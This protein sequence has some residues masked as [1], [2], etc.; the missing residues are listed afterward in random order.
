MSTEQ[1]YTKYN[2]DNETSDNET[3]DD[4]TSVLSDTSS[5]FEN[6]VANFALLAKNLYKPDVN[7][8]Q[9]NNL[10]SEVNFTKGRIYSLYNSLDDNIESGIKDKNGAKLYANSNLK[11]D[12]SA[13]TFNTTKNEVTSIINIDSSDRD[14]QVY[15]Q[16]TNLQLRLPRVYKNILNFQIVQI[17]L[18]SAF[19]YFRKAKNNITISINEQSRYLDSENNVINNV[20]AIVDPN[21]F[22]KLNSITNTIREGSYDINSLINEL[23]IH[24][25]TPPLF[26]DFIGGFNQFVPLFAANGDLFASFN[27]PGDYYFDSVL[28]EYITAPTAE[29]IVTKYFETRYAGQTS[30]TIDNIKIA[31]YYPV[32]KE[33][34]LDNNYNGKAIDF[35]LANLSLLLPT[36]T[37]RTRCLYY[38]QGLNDTYVLSVIQ[39]NITILDS[40]RLAHTFR[41]TLINKYNVFYN[42]FNN[43]ISINSPSLN[44]SLVNLI[45]T[46]KTTYYN[47]EFVKYGIT[48]NNYTDLYVQ[49][50]LYLAILTDMYNFLQY[51]FST[52]FGITYNTFTLDYYG[53]MSNYV[54]L[55]SGCNANIS[56]NYDINVITN[57]IT[58]I[59]NNILTYYQTP[60]KYYW[61]SLSSN[62][63][64]NFSNAT[65]I[66]YYSGNPYNLQSDI[67]EE[68]HTLINNDT[69]YSSKLLNHVDAVV[70]INNTSYTIF[71]FKSSY[72]QTLQVEVL[73]RPTKYRYPEYNVNYDLSHSILFDNSYNFILNSSNNIFIDPSI[74]VSPLPGFTSI[75]DSNFGITFS[76]SYA[77]WLGSNASI[78]PNQLYDYYSFVTPLPDLLNAIAYKYTT[79][80]NVSAYPYGTNFSSQLKVFLYRDIGAFYA[81]ILSYGFES[82]YNYIL[83]NSIPTSVSEINIDFPSYQVPSSNQIFYIIIRSDSNTPVLTNYVI[84]PYFKTNTYTTLSNS[85]TN[86]NPLADPQQNQ[87]LNNFLYSRSYDIDYLHLPSQSNLYQANPLKNKFF[88]DIS[89]NDVPMGYDTN[90]V[91]TDL[92][93]YIG[94]TTNQAVINPNSILRVDPINKYIFSLQSDYNST[95]QTYF[96]NNTLNKLFTPQSISN[97]IPTIPAQRQYS[98][99]H[100]YATIYL[101]NS[102]NQPPLE[103]QFISSNVLPYNSNQFTNTLN[104]YNFDVNGNLQI[105]FGVYGLSLI[106]G[107]GT[108]TI[109]KYMFKSVFNQ[110]S[111]NQTNSNNY[112]SD[113]NLNIKYLGI[114]YNSVLINKEINSIYLSNA[115]TT[116]TFSSYNIYNSSNTNFGFGAEGGTYYE[117]VSNDSNYL[118]GFSENSNTITNDY[119]NGYTIM[120]FDSNNNVV[121]FIGLTGSLVPYPY[122]SDAVASNMYLDSTVSPN[123]SSLIVPVVKTLPDTSRG[124][125]SSQ[126][127]TQTQAQY[128]QSMPIGT[129][130]FAY[131]SNTNLINANF[132]GFSNLPMPVDKIIMDISGYLLTQDTDFKIYTYGLSNNFIFSRSFTSDDIF[133]S[134]IT[135]ISVAA[136]ENEYAF[137]GFSN[138][139]LPIGSSIPTPNIN[140]LS[141]DKFIIKTYNPITYAIQTRVITNFLLYP[142][143]STQLHSFTY[144]NYGGFTIGFSYTDSNNTTNNYCYSIAN[145][146]SNIETSF[147][148][149]INLQTYVV[150]T[151]LTTKFVTY[152]NPREFAGKFYVASYDTSNKITEFSLIDPTTNE[153]TNPNKH[154]VAY[155]SCNYIF[156]NSNACKITSYY[157]SIPFDQFAI[158]RSPVNDIL[159]GFTSVESKKFYLLS[160]Y[161]SPVSSAYD[162]NANFTLSSNTFPTAVHEM[163]AGYNGALWF[164]D[165]SGTIYGNRNTP[166]D[167][168]PKTILYAWQ[169][170]Y[171][172]QRVI[173]NNISRSVNLL[174]DLTSLD[175][176]EL[177]HTQLFLYKDTNSFTADL[178]KPNV[179]SWGNESNFFISDTQYSGYYFNAYTS[180]LPLD[181]SPDYYYLAVRNYSPTEKSQVYMRFSLANRYDY[182]YASFKDISNE[183]ILR[184]TNTQ[185]FNPNYNSN[186]L[187]FNS[188][189]IF[190]T[191]TFGS[192]IIANY[193]GLTLSNVKGFGDFMKYYISYYNIYLSNIQLLDTINNNVVSNISNFISYD[194]QY[195]IPPTATNRQNYTDP[196]LFSILWKTA[197]QPQYLELEDNWGFG[198]NLGYTKEDTQY[199]LIQT[200]TSFYKILDDY[201][202]LRLNNE[203]DVN[204][205]DTSGKEKLSATHE[206]TGSTKAYYGK[207]L[208]APFGSYAQTMVMNPIVFNPP[209]GRLD[210]V[211]FTWYDVTNNIIDNSDCE[212]NAVMQIVESIDIANTILNPPILNPR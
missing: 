132:Y 158:T 91:S 191:K 44:S 187:S 168:V 29:Q 99:V 145:S 73:P 197:L 131:T 56:S 27:L 160:S 189:F 17:K 66:N 74:I 77:L 161:S 108:W 152:Q 62:P 204:R 80:I 176:P 136:N 138:V 58:P 57:N 169:L 183:V 94:Y 68:Y 37:P 85:L 109:Q 121:P 45:N 76:N 5:E 81:D 20:A 113:P 33:L 209:L 23:I 192:N 78:N 39:G 3:S 202:V 104:G 13:N 162:S 25:N 200:A 72:R 166:N 198:W 208:L 79:T 135:F 120:A 157:M 126:S 89:Y 137:L 180:L 171:P 75:N 177:Y 101:P 155:N 186:L 59:S 196:I 188:N 90:N 144:N 164:N 96:Y 165:L 51:V 65:N 93:H 201:I 48:S 9:F 18:L 118:Y 163:E 16:P 71:K 30:Y 206:S 84:V 24:L 129:N 117:F 147:S 42:T 125:S 139:A 55:R 127:Q 88:S 70:N 134:N 36:E 211:T 199:D 185:N 105:G 115:I 64:V 41:Y 40:Y 107:Q 67:P 43:N 14:K 63:S 49:N 167:G 114:Y 210:K 124:P 212:W 15:T 60:P 190:T 205:V 203:F 143:E 82:P 87:N 53:N 170:F 148:T 83:S 116:L 184:S 103:S 178:L 10:E 193:Y 122:Y 19:F 8:L 47:E 111:W 21:Y 142:F 195:I 12:I 110:S 97:Y 179:C 123:G 98:Q 26:Y 182:G 86:F 102:I 156:T 6:D 35:T 159:Y 7:D 69:F 150:N 4:T 106:P 194:L 1:Y 46:K 207:L 112:T 61:H 149:I 130:Y 95:S 32:L 141:Q 28:N 173:Y 172:T 174:P 128:E 151:G 175:Y 133:S 50:S 119:N 146:D 52:Q 2:S 34:L 181:P 153:A 92:T 31:Y 100:Y 38:F 154:L 54:Y 11:L 22:K 140:T